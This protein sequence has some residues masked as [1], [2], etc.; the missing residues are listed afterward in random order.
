MRSGEFGEHREILTGAEPVAQ[1]LRFLR[2][3][4]SKPRPERLNQIHLVAMLDD[5]PAQVVQVFRLGIGPGC[6]EAIAARAGRSTVN[7]SVT[8]S[9]SIA[10]SGQRSSE[11]VA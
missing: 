6:R 5:A 11:S 8:I 3:D 1:A 7:P 2:P 9:K 10:L 4:F